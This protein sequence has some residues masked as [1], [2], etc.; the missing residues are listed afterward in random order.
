MADH[1]GED[2]AAEWVAGWRMMQDENWPERV[3]GVMSSLAFGAAD[4]AAGS[5]ASVD[6]G[7]DDWPIEVYAVCFVGDDVVAHWTVCHTG[8]GLWATRPRASVTGGDG[9]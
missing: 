8:D 7:A 5:A 2:E 1:P 9:G 4:L 3:S 6:I